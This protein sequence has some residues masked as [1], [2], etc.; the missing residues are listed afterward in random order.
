MKRILKGLK[1]FFLGLVLYIVS[2]VLI[3]LLS[4]WGMIETI[5]ESSKK[6]FGDALYYIGS[7]FLM[8]A[9]MIDVFGNVI[10]QVPMTRILLDETSI[11]KFGSREDTISYVL[12]YNIVNGGLS[13][14][15]KTLC[16]V[17]DFFDK[18]HCRKTYYYKNP[19]EGDKVDYWF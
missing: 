6:K 12:G 15:G 11:Y 4:P 13:K 5:I 2:I 14:H 17:L 3:V 1:S 9:T 19:M 8:F 7:I 18:D 16:K 10:M